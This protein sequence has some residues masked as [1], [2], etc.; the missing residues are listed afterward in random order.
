[1]TD[2]NNAIN[3]QPSSSSKGKS[4]F[5]VFKSKKD[6]SSSGNISNKLLNIHEQSGGD[7]KEPKLIDFLFSD[8][9]NILHPLKIDLQPTTSPP[10][11]TA[12]SPKKSPSMF[13]KLSLLFSK[14]H[15]SDTLILPAEENTTPASQHFGDNATSDEAPAS[16][17]FGGN[18]TNDEAV[19]VE[20][21]LDFKPKE[22]DE[23]NEEKEVHN[24]EGYASEDHDQRVEREEEVAEEVKEQSI[25]SSS[26]ISSSEAS[27]DESEIIEGPTP[28]LPAHEVEVK[29]KESVRVKD[30]APSPPQA[31]PP[32]SEPS[33]SPSPSPSK[34]SSHP[35]PSPGSHDLSSD[36]S[37]SSDDEAEHAAPQ[38]LIKKDKARENNALPKKGFFAN[39]KSFFKSLWSRGSKETKIL[40]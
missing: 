38:K 34:L 6:K 33:P 4:M 14:K 2:Q 27:D 3:T 19:L 28:R 10:V 36:S 17:H 5:D 18:A 35:S 37:Q 39:V 9:E 15:T 12:S 29:E 22:G 32:S 16:Q 24:N 30:A 23:L 40:Q 31:A 11:S 13:A 1:V 7:A 21:P 26:A 25:A 8:K 20:S